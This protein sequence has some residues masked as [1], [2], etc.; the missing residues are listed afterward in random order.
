M[1][2][3]TK[4]YTFRLSNDS[5]DY[6]IDDRYLLIIP[7]LLTENLSKLNSCLVNN[8]S[9]QKNNKFNIINL[10]NTNKYGV[11]DEFNNVVL[12]CIYDE[13]K[14]KED[15]I[16]YTK[17]N[18]TKSLWCTKNNKIEINPNT[19]EI[20]SD[21]KFSVLYSTETRK[22]RV[23]EFIIYDRETNKF[24]GLELKFNNN[25]VEILGEVFKNLE[26][27]TKNKE[28]IITYL[29]KKLPGIYIFDL[30][31]NKFI[32]IESWDFK[33]TLKDNL[34]NTIQLNKEETYGLKKQI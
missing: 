15:I 5:T 14:I 34:G 33:T 17:D 3:I 19:C 31:E 20:L 8:S 7:E 25:N 26:F 27:L 10:C 11:I 21:D 16:T 28:V 23:I 22:D 29:T 13:I 4:E 24:S 30:K 1:I 18:I 2:N 12:S 32:E 6:E 9:N